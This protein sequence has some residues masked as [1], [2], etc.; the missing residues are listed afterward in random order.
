[1]TE[2]TPRK[3]EVRLSASTYESSYKPHKSIA[4]TAT[5]TTQTPSFR[6]L[7]KASSKYWPKLYCMQDWMDAYS[8]SYSL[9][10]DGLPIQDPEEKKEVRK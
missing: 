4:S 7:L 9:Y 10:R 2:R 3:L 5:I 1:M 8:Y 6:T